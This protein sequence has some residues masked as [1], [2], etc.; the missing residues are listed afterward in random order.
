MPT[1]QYDDYSIFSAFFLSAA[2]LQQQEDNSE[3]YTALQPVKTAMVWL[4]SM[5]RTKR[6]PKEAS[7]RTQK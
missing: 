5:V 6:K 3:F 1:Q 2:D 4:T 7:E